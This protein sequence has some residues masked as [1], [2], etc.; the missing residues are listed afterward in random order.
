MVKDKMESMKKSIFFINT[1][2]K[3]LTELNVKKIKK[4]KIIFKK[5]FYLYNSGKISYLD[6]FSLIP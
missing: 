4:Q 3:L 6:F 1:Y 2:Q 5:R